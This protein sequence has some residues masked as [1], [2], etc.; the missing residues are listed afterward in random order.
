M[1]RRLGEDIRRLCRANFPLMPVLQ[2]SQRS[3]E[4]IRLPSA[5]RSAQASSCGSLPGQSETRIDG[6]PDFDDGS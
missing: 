6:L 5:Y 4:Q 2:V 1:T 3:F